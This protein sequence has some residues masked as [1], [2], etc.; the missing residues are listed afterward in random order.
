MS[1]S[2]KRNSASGFTLVELLIVIVIIGILS[3]V[4][5]TVINPARQQLKA[6]EAS[7]RS[8]VEK[9]CLALYACAASTSDARLC[10]TALEIGA[11][12]AAGI[13]A[14]AAYCVDAD[15]NE[16]NLCTAAPAGAAGNT[17]AVWGT[18][19]TCRFVCNYNFGTS[20]PTNLFVSA[21]AGVNTCTIPAM[22]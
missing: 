3:G 9:S 18:V 8:V 7:L 15:G 19:G 11:N 4:L 12:M 6:R 14:G 10:D 5:I 2:L 20:T 1:K 16:A 17:I 13:P 21:T 22:E